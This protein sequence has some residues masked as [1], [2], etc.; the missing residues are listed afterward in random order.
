MKCAATVQGV[1]ASNF[2]IINT[3]FYE[4]KQSEI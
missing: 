2:W 3:D 1:T 4:R